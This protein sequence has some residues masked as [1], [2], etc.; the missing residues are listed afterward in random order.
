LAAGRVVELMDPYPFRGAVRWVALPSLI[1]LA[2]AV[3]G[4][5]PWLIFGGWPLMIP[6]AYVLLGASA[7]MPVAA[8]L[9]LGRRPWA[10]VATAA[11]LGA[12]SVPVAQ[13][14]LSTFFGGIVIPHPWTLAALDAVTA[15]LLVLAYLGRLRWR[16]RGLRRA[17]AGLGLY[18]VAPLVSGGVEAW[19]EPDEPY[20]GWICYQVVSGVVLHASALTVALRV[21]EGRKETAP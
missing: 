4:V 10:A 11:G 6:W 5:G 17:V 20:L 14:L 8:A 12:L 1:L 19:M 3:Q 18:A 9:T 15:V 2:G 7:C 21:A 13:R 16:G